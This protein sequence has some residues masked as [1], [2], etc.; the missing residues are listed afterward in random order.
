[1]DKLRR[2]VGAHGMRAC[3]LLGDKNIIRP[4]LEYIEETGRFK[5]EYR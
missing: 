1:M 2:E 5:L 3:T 4:T